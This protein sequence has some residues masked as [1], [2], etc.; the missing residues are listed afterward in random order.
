MEEVSPASMYVWI[1]P[2]EEG[3]GSP[4]AWVADAKLVAVIGEVE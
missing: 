4:V 2:G 3:V 1:V